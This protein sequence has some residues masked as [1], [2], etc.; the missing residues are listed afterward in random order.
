MDSCLKTD[1]LVIGSGISGGIA[2]LEIADKGVEVTLVTRSTEPKVSSTY[3]AQGG[4]IY[5]G[6]R[7]SAKKLK[8]DIL[9]AGAGLSYPKAV[10][11]LAENGPGLVKSLLISKLNIQFD[12][13]KDQSL[14]L[15][16]EGGHS[17]P[18]IIHVADATGKAIETA[19]LN[20][21]KTHPNV[22]ILSHFT[23]VDLLTPA[24]HSRD[25]ISIYK[26]NFCVGA[27]ILNRA[28][29]SIQRILAKK[30][31]LATGGPGQIFRR[32]TNP[33]GA[34]GDGIAMAYRAGARVINN[35]YIQFHP[36][37]FYHE[38]KMTF[39]ISEAVRGAGAKLVNG[40]G[41]PFMEKYNPQWKDLAPRDVVAISIHKEMLARDVSNV[42]LDLGSYLSKQDIID[43]F[44]N[45]YK[46][47]MAN[48][49]DP[50][51]AL[52]PVVPAA[53][54]AC[55]GVWVDEWSKTTITNL[56]AVGEVAATGVHGANRLASTSLLEGLVWGYNAAQNISDGLPEAKH[57]PQQYLPEWEDAGPELPDPVLISQDMSSIKN[58]M[59]NYVGLVRTPVRLQRAL[60]ELRNLENEIE[61][62]YRVSKLTDDLV[63][64]RNAVRAAI[65]VTSAAWAN[66]SSV[67]CHYRE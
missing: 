41:I 35:E 47:C 58:I 49:I 40:D 13:T 22:R 66:K 24:H 55:G 56:Y 59:W 46:N 62:F 28:D 6:R 1:V 29:N 36:T 33:P 65:I 30:T 18:R 64:L 37:T 48:G 39:L 25:R 26:P 10:N 5:K 32:T 45:I 14:H 12:K 63:G 4:I 20:A 67:G 57:Y 11:I 23:A 38:Y 60:R 7:D 42:Y 3:F 52:I 53:H 15:A 31:V 44:P 9:A 17:I 61:R 19:L 50:C 43:K 16:M 27:Y 34:R 21:L 51:S 2:A 8:E 54:Y